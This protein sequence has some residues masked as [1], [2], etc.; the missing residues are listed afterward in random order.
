MKYPNRLGLNL[1]PVVLALPL[2]GIALSSCALSGGNLVREEAKKETV[3][4]DGQDVCYGAIINDLVYRMT[5]DGEASYLASTELVELLKSDAPNSVKGELVEA[6]AYAQLSRSITLPPMR[7]SIDAPGGS[8]QKINASRVTLFNS[9]LSGADF[10]G[11]WWTKCSI[12]DSN[13][14]GASMQEFYGDRLKLNG[15]NLRGVDLRDAHLRKASFVECDLSG[16]NLRGSGLSESQFSG[17]FLNGANLRGSRLT[18]G[19]FSSTFLNGANCRNVGA[20]ACSF[21]DCDLVGVDF[22]GALLRRATGL[23]YLQLN[24]TIL[25][26]GTVLPDSAHEWLDKLEI[27]PD[28]ESRSEEPP[29]GPAP[30][31]LGM[32]LVQ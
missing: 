9:D 18:G 20:L 25:S 2:I 15:S 12:V 6:L 26:K 28:T 3:K 10:T 1:A 5:L 23:S 21:V 24:R 14:A 4:P 30:C 11:S 16:A 31:Y 17:T 13:L 22:R 32:D 27:L 29:E 8:F 7:I 19:R